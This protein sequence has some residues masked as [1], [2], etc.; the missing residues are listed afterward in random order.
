MDGRAK[1]T[2]GRAVRHAGEQR[3]RKSLPSLSLSFRLS[4]CLSLNV[5]E[6]QRANP[7]NC[8]LHHDAR[9]PRKK[10]SL[11]YTNSN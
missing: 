2:G 10:S 3:E 5:E 9:Q 1:R 8:L 7:L 11:T 4:V 6:D